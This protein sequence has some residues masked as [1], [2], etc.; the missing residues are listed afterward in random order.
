MLAPTPPLEEEQTP[1][2]LIFD[3][4]LKLGGYTGC[5]IFFGKYRY[6]EAGSISLKVDGMTRMA[7]KQMFLEQ[8]LLRLIPMV[9]SYSIKDSILT[10]YGA[11]KEELIRLDGRKGLSDLK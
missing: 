5:N 10:L 11:D 6:G 7:G 2:Y 9:T 4:S 1:A 8:N 3:D